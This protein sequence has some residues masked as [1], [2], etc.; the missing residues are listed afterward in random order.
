MSGA[1]GRPQS[2]PP[3]GTGLD[4]DLLRLRLLAE[5]RNRGASWTVIGRALGVSGKQAKRHVK[6]LARET[7]RQ[8]LLAKGR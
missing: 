7:Q 8:V 1:P 2:A 4:R 5:A 3:A 6:A